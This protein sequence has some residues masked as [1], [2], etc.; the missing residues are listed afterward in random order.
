MPVETPSELIHEAE[1]GKS[2][3]TP[4]IALGGVTIVVS[5]AVVAVCVIVFAA[6][7]LS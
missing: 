6:Y 4:F 5:L 7:Y 1:E 3:K 2:D